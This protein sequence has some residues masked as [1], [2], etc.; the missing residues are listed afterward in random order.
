[1]KNNLYTIY[2]KLS[3]RYG[4]V[5]AFPTDAFASMA[6]SKIASNPQADLDLSEI[7]VCR[8]GSIDIETGVITPEVAPVRI[9]IDTSKISVDNM[10]SPSEGNKQFL[11]PLLTEGLF[12]I[13]FF[14]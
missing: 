9:E 8:I 11:C 4:E 3:L 2:N 1:M 5:K 7:D 10:C 13:L 12:M 14:L 6:F